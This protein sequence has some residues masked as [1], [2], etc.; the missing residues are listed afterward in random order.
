[1]KEKRNE[2]GKKEGWRKKRE[3]KRQALFWPIIVTQLLHFLHPQS[4]APVLPYACAHHSNSRMHTPPQLGCFLLFFSA[5]MG[6]TTS[7]RRL[8]KKGF[9]SSYGSRGRV[10]HGRG[11]V[12][13]DSCGRM[14]R[15]SYLNHERGA[16]KSELSM[17]WT[18]KAHPQR[19]ASASKAP[20]SN[21]SIAS[22]NSTTNQKF[23]YLNLRVLG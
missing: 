21:G 2:E 10:H 7:K 12:A 23:K 15:R 17:V 20:P 8:W 18:V 4:M 14:L 22:L 16:E 13:A 6:N 1:M 5:A 3:R 11:T 19:S 9:I